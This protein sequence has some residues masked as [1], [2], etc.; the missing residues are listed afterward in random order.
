MNNIRH[1]DTTHPTQAFIEC[2]HNRQPKNG[3]KHGQFAICEAFGKQTDSFKI[4]ENIA[5]QRCDE[6][7]VHHSHQP[8]TVVAMAQEVSRSHEAVLVCA[9]LQGTGK[10]PVRRYHQRHAHG[11]EEHDRPFTIGI[12][13]KAEHCVA[14]ILRGV[15]REKQRHDRQATT[16]QIEI[17]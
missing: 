3:I 14:A 17:L 15:K 2:H 5:R 4:G 8:C 16:C 7:N 1:N 9:L 11:R 12:A 10:Q 13:G 6:Q